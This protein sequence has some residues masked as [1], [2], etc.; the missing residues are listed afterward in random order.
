MNERIGPIP[1]S[2][3][4]PLTAVLAA[5]R[6]VGFWGSVMLPLAYLPVMVALSGTTMLGAL[7]LLLALNVVCLLCGR[8]YVP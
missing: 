7:S 5:V 1:V 4:N 2:S 8:H 6:R 3:S